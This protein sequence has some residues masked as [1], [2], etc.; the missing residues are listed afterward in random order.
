MEVLASTQETK[1][2]CQVFAHTIENILRRIEREGGLKR[3]QNN[4]KEKKNLFL[5]GTEKKN[6][7]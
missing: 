4:T 2:F 6:F 7:A 1:T 3:G 5:C